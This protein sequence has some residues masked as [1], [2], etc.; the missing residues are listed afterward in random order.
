MGAKPLT[1]AIGLMKYGVM[2]FSVAYLFLTVITALHVVALSES[3]LVSFL[4]LYFYT[5]VVANWVA[6]FS[7]S[8]QDPGLNYYKSDIEK[9]TEQNYCP[10]C[11]II[12][13]E[14][15]HHWYTRAMV[16]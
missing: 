13:Q 16:F 3:V 2:L 10:D 4:A 8:N 15:S 9:Q 11:D 1:P 6:I 7:H 14:Q 5:H 12:R